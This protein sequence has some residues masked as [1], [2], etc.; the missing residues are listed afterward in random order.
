MDIKTLAAEAESTYEHIRKLIKGMTDKQNSVIIQFQGALR[1][2]RRLTE[3]L[4]VTECG[5]DVF[6]EVRGVTVRVGAAGGIDLPAVR[7]Y[8]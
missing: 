7:S 6:T 1:E 8:P 5:G 3:T 4:H 2:E